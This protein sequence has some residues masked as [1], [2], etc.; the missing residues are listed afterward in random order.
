[1]VL[2]FKAW[3]IEHGAWKLYQVA[4]RLFCVSGFFTLEGHTLAW[5][6]LFIERVNY[7]LCRGGLE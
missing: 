7:A 6:G 4:D 3:S 1:M 5:S 2:G